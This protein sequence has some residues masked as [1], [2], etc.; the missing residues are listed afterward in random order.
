MA[1]LGLVPPQ[2]CRANMSTADTA[3][4]QLINISASILSQDIGILLEGDDLVEKWITLCLKYGLRTLACPGNQ[5]RCPTCSTTLTRP[6]EPQ[7]CTPWCLHCQG[8]HSPFA[9]ICHIRKQYDDASAGAALRQSLRHRQQM[10]RSTVSPPLLTVQYPRLGRHPAHSQPRS[11]CSPL[12]LRRSANSGS[13]TTCGIVSC[14]QDIDQN[15]I[16][17]HCPS[18]SAASYRHNT[19]EPAAARRTRPNLSCPL[20]MS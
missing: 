2:Q 12:P 15:I 14:H 17:L 1:P 9:E 11:H 18:F 13:P 8:H 10:A 3:A 16:S 4:S 7:P 5:R 6:Y 20:P 19:A